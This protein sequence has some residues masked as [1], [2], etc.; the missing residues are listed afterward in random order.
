M[1]VDVRKKVGSYACSLFIFLSLFFSTSTTAQFYN[2]LQME[3]GKNRIQYN[4]F[5]WQSMKFEKFDTYF[6]LGGKELAVFTAEVAQKNMEELEKLF[7]YTIDEK[8]QFV[9]YNK[10]SDYRQSNIGIGISDNFNI[11]G[12]TRLVGSKVIIYNE[13]DHKK[14]EQ[15]IR[16]GIADVLMSQIMYGGNWKEKL[17]NS[18]LLNLPDWYVKGLI[19]FV[20]EDWNPDIDN[21][22]KDGI[23]TGKFKKF[24]RLEGNDALNAGHSLWNYIAQTYGKSVIPNILYMTSVSRNME[25]GF[26]FVIGTSLKNL[27]RDY[28][29]Y[30][31]SKYILTERSTLSPTKEFSGVKKPKQQKKITQFKISPD[32]KFA[33]YV[34]NQMGQYKLYLY[35]YEKEKSKKILKVGKKLERINDYSYPIVTWHPTG[36]LLAIITEEKGEVIL[37]YYD[38][39][40]KERLKRPPLYDFD[41]VLDIA[42][43]DDGKNIAFSAVKDGSTDIY[44]YIVAANKAVQITQDLFDDLNPRFINKSTQLI[45]S[46]NRNDDTLRIGDNY[47]KHPP[48][49]THDLFIYDLVKKNTNVLKRFTNSPDIN[50]KMPSQFDKNR[51]TYLGDNNGILN[52]Y[53]A[54]YDSSISYVDTTEHYRYFTVIKPISNS[55]RNI[56]EYDINPETKKYSQIV[57]YNNRYRLYVGQEADYKS[58]SDLKLYSPKTITPTN[59]YA[60]SDTLIKPRKHIKPVKVYVES[61]DKKLQPGQIDINNYRFE[62]EGT[63]VAKE[64]SKSVENSNKV[65]IKIGAEK[66]S[67]QAPKTT[68]ITNQT[69]ETSSIVAKSEFIIPKQRNYNL[70]FNVDQVVSQ[71]D[72]GFINSN[73]QKFTGS[74]VY[75]NPGLNGLIKLGISDLFEDYRFVGAVRLS[76]DLKSNEY[77]LSYENRVNRWDKQLVLHRQ[78]FPVVRNSGAPKVLTQQAKYLVKYPFNEVASVRASVAYRND[79]LTFLSTDLQGL[80][81]PTQYENWGIAKLEYVFDNTINKGLNLYNGTRLKLF[82]EYFNQLKQTEVNMAVLGFDIRNYKKIHR[83]LIWAN[84]IAASTSFGKQ[85]LVYY[86]GSVDNWLNVGKYSTFNEKQAIDYSQN[87][88]YQTLATNLRGF[89]QNI[90][91]GSNFAVIN[92]E[93]RFP[94]FNYFFNRPLRSDF[95]NNFQIIGFGDVGAAWTGVSPYSN[96]NSFNT[97]TISQQPIK[98]FLKSQREPVVGGYGFGLR[99]RL[100]GYF[101]RTD[102]AWGVEDGE[103]KPYIFYLSFSL[104]F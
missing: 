46:S 20:A 45:F 79:R 51:I 72:Y 95:L 36:S 34:T 29:N 102:W 93:L 57:F 74:A 103:V 82:G 35:N 86:L 65:L 55:S 84:R 69:V 12:Q 70:I 80:Q 64:P 59:E 18:T 92:S 87:Y 52:R 42:Y 96:D 17:R 44:N 13:G 60:N 38:I 85:K 15:Q 30:Y 89:N 49:A 77:F 39:E 104:D 48:R 62:S 22:T 24:N 67:V 4:D 63:S 97:E 28:Q 21:K 3:F 98:V 68:F 73:Y 25:S 41:K 9:V 81:E 5:L 10:L 61:D 100:F 54:Q 83:N 23:I 8:I 56:L 47:Q 43:S 37:S 26:Y 90:R 40:K 2:G 19:Q 16:A 1:K 11:G 88:G 33:T 50:E 31:D 53:L 7:D 71:L 75:F 66:D 91:N 6:Y 27:F 101:I 94:V 14:L 99:S 58:Q 78:S 32:G 76:A